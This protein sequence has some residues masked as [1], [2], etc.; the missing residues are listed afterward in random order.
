MAGV[1]PLKVVGKRDLQP[2]LLQDQCQQCSAKERVRTCL[3]P[4]WGSVSFYPSTHGL[5]RGLHSDAVL[6]LKPDV[7][8][9][10][11]DNPLRDA[12]GFRLALAFLILKFHDDGKDS[13]TG[14]GHIP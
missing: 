6:R 2:L 1:R 11:T 9:V 12:A 8:R 13:F 10:V 3:R 4:R 7:A 14:A 5:G